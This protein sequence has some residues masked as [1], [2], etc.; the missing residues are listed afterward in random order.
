[1]TGGS[2]VAVMHA[3][4]GCSYGFGRL[5]DYMFRELRRRG[6]VR[7]LIFR[8]SCVD[9]ADCELV[10]ALPFGN[11]IPKIMTWIE[12]AMGITTS[13]FT[14]RMFDRFARRKIPRIPDGMLFIQ[15]DYYDTVMHAKRLGYRIVVE[16]GADPEYINEQ[17]AIEYEKYGIRHH[18]MFEAR[19][20]DLHAKSIKQADY[21]VTSEFNKGTFASRGF[22]PDRIFTFRRGTYTVDR[23]ERDY[24]RLNFL[25]MANLTLM[26]G[27]QYLL[28]AWEQ[29]GPD[30]G[31]ATLTICGG[32][33]PDFRKILDRYVRRNPSISYAGPV[34]PDEYYKKAHVFVHPSL[35]ETE[36]RVVIEAMM[37]GLPVIATPISAHHISNGHDGFQVEPRDVAGLAAAIRHF[38]DDPSRAETMGNN[39][40]ENARGLTYD[41][42]S[43]QLADIIKE[44]QER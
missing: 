5:T 30:V 29:M 42:Y 40:Y 9:Y 28:E 33:A 19:L 34:S 10:H 37:H 14:Y 17:S 43:H 41:S 2:I 44:I 8:D 1:M 25:V 26:K 39:A 21:L 27:V 4:I 12:M 38:C 20:G 22:S 24:E 15:P 31:D 32:C 36:P 11:K 7:R 18:P 16:T 23:Y 3:D 13:Y 35:I 6:Q